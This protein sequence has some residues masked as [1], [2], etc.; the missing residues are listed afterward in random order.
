MIGGDLYL[1]L[2]EKVQINN[3]LK[4]GIYICT[5]TRN[6]NEST[7]AI[8]LEVWLSGGGAFS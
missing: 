2:V 7:C 8:S 3:V 4:K 1:C 5:D 6:N